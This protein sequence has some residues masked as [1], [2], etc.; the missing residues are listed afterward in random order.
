MKSITPP[1]FS[2]CVRPQRGPLHGCVARGGRT[3]DGRVAEPLSLASYRRI[4]AEPSAG[5]ARAGAVS[6]AES[7]TPTS[8]SRRNFTPR[9]AQV[10]VLPV[11]GTAAKRTS[12]CAGESSSSARMVASRSSMR[13]N[14]MI[15]LVCTNLANLC[16]HAVYSVLASFFPQEAKAKGMSEDGVGFVFA[17]FAAVIF[18]CSPCAGRLM[19]RHGKVWVYIW[20]ISLVC[21]STICFSMASLM[22][23][24]VPFAVWCFSMRVMQGLG[25]ALEETAMYSIIA[26]LDPERVTLYLGICEISTGLGYMIGPP[27]GGFLFSAGGFAMPFLVLGLAV[28]PAAFLLYSYVPP[29]AY[30]LSKGDQSSNDV[31]LQTLLKSPQVMVMAVAAMLANSDYAF[32]EPTLGEHAAEMGVASSPD[33]IGMLFSVAMTS[34]TLS[35]PVIGVLAKRE[36]FGPRPVIVCGLLLQ[37]LGFLIIG[38]SPLLR[39]GRHPSMSQMISSLIMFGV[40][41]AMSMTPVMDDMM[42]SCGTHADEYV[43]GLSA[44]MASSFSLG[45]MVGPLIGSFLTQRMGFAWA[46]TFMA[47]VLL[48]HIASIL[49]LD[50]LRPRQRAT[51]YTELTAVSIPLAD[52]ASE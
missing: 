29:D 3:I 12:G 10:D 19:T 47:A 21:V 45:Q 38:P 11:S 6:P 14:K 32:L 13:N 7:L 31:S 27:L 4:V 35:C 17:V 34:Y 15:V 20:G 39:L 51:V 18:V 44:L 49:V 48:L 33:A 9:E 36:H 25:A 5:C 22:P 1:V 52:S 23:A 30:R 37:L 26:D 40:G 43:N 8:A 24:G 50:I 42:H 41:E 16:C 2:S 46:C 28:A